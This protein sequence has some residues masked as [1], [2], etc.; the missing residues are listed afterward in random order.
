[1]RPLTP[2]LTLTRPS[3]EELQNLVQEKP[4]MSDA[5]VLSTPPTDEPSRGLEYSHSDAVRKLKMTKQYYDS[6]QLW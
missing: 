4:N 2:V 5:P 1:M 6:S 3:T